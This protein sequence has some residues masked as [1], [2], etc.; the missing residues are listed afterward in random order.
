VQSSEFQWRNVLRAVDAGP[1]VVSGSV[2]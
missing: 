1:Q 2:W